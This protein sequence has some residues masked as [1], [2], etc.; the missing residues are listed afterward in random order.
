MSDEQAKMNRLDRNQSGMR[1]RPSSVEELDD[2]LVCDWL[3]IAADGSVTVFTGKTEVGQNIRTSLAQAVADELRLPLD[4]IRMIMADTDLVPF[5]MGTFG[6][7]TTPQ[8]ATRL[9]KVAATAREALIGMAAE[10]WHVDRGELRVA[11]GAIMHE[12]SGRSVGFGELTQGQ[13]LMHHFDDSAPVTPATAWTVAGRP[14]GKIAGRAMVTGAHQYTPDITRPGMQYGKVLR[15]PAFGATLT[16]IDTSAAEAMPDVRVVRDGDF[17][18]VVAPRRARA[19]QALN[20]IHA[21]WNFTG[22]VSMRDL[23]GYLREHPAPPVEPGQR[24]GPQSFEQGSLETGLDAA[25]HVLEHTYTHAYIAHAP[26]E[27]RA[28]L[29]E[30]HD[31]KLTV[32]TGTQRPFGVRTELA[33]TFGMPEGQIR[34]I[35]PD[36]GSGYGGKHTGEAAIEAARLARGAGVPVKLIWTREEEFTWA[37]FRPAGVIDITSA[38]R[39]DGTITAWEF[40]NYTSGPPGMHTPY[41]VPHQRIAFHPT[42]SPLRPGSYRAL[43]ATANNFARETHMDELAHAVGMDPLAFRLKNPK[44]ERLRAVLQAAAERFGW[45]AATPAPGHGFGM[46]GGTEKGSYVATCAEVA[47]DARGNVTIVRVVQAFECGAIVNPEGL[48]NQIEGAI[49]QGLG[50]AL[51]EAITFENGRVLSDR[52]SRYRVPRFGDVPAIE[53]V[54]LDRRDLPSTGAGE[55][56][57]IGIAPAISNAIFAATGRR[58][59]AMPMLP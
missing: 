37:Y 15:P 8:M 18:G 58:L 11:D 57:I 43:A 45:N 6:S 39:N 20:A 4:A 27:P 53:V 23:F 24:G 42:E 59:R 54:L 14:H 30:W 38:V 31:G 36:T 51:F 25:D 48:R 49:I 52:F 21:E 10:R 16:S 44:D 46:A 28:A 41:D 34:V 19:T 33:N 2:T 12:P 56:P 47:V 22:Q 40:H 1:G 17:V 50:G 55:T 3:H 5:D 9:R 32:W 29:A 35:V 13:P 26:L 7:Q